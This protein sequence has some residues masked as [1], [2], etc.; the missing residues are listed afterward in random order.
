MCFFASS[1]ILLSL[2]FLPY[3][4]GVWVF[5]VYVSK[6]LRFYL[7]LSIFLLVSYPVIKFTMLKQNNF[8]TFLCYLRLLCI[9]GL[10]KIVWVVA[11]TF[12]INRFILDLLFLITSKIVPVMV[13]KTWLTKFKRAGG[14]NRVNSPLKGNLQLF[15]VN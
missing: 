12:Q 9:Q 5:V 2:S 14:R 6:R 8:F 11:L 10:E 1:S 13:G 3:Y 4:L 15:I 7:F